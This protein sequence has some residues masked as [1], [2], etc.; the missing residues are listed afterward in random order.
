MFNAN[1]VANSDKQFLWQRALL[2]VGD[3]TF[4]M[5][6][7]RRCFLLDAYTEANSWKRLLRGY[8]LAEAKG[9]ELLKTLWD[10]LDGRQPAAEQLKRNCDQRD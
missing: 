10:Q 6:A 2:S 4:P 8:T 7:Q 5:T 3:Y 1:G 9:R